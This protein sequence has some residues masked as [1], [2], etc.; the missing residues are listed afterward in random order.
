[1]FAIFERKL[2]IVGMIKSTKVLLIARNFF[3]ARRMFI[4]CVGAN[5]DCWARSPAPA[6]RGQ[7]PEQRS[8]VSVRPKSVLDC[9]I[10][11]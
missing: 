9:E 7:N 11:I 1:M 6:Q 4:V 10:D 5:V 3:S 8:V 2:T